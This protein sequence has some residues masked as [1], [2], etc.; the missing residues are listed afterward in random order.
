MRFK[1]QITYPIIGAL[2]AAGAPL[3]SFLLRFVAFRKVR[4]E[5]FDDL[6][7][8]VFFYLY[9]LL[10]T[11]LVF[12]TVGFIVGWHA[13]RLRRGEA[14]YHDLAEHDSLT[15]LHNDRAFTDRY[16]RA[17]ERAVDARQPLAII[18]I[19]VDQL[20]AINDAFG[21]RAGSKALVHVADALRSS[22]RAADI[23]ARWGGD[24]F[25]ILLEGADAAA[26]MRVAQEVITY[27]RNTPVQLERKTVPVSV[28]IGIC[29]AG[30]PS[31]NS[32]LFAAADRALFIG[33][34]RG[35]NTIEVVS[36]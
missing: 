9:D 5:P 25:A 2:L 16:R 36:I 22:K 24:E 20:K 21:H 33:K 19:D 23:A 15:G 31:A 11:S 3:G 17:L 35:R 14:L 4:R 28:T 12:G 1:A 8:N 32:D 18:L 29:T 27:L 7:T 26:A 10:A 34:A 13:D 30:Q 6:R